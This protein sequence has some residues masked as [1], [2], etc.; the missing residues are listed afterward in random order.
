M[1]IE[2][3]VNRFWVLYQMHYYSQGF[4]SFAQRSSAKKIL[5]HPP[6]SFHDWKPKFFFIK[7]GVIPMKMTFR[8]KEDVVTETIQTPHSET[9]YQDLKDVSSIEL[10]E[11]ALVAAGMSLYWKMDCEDRQVYME[12]DKIVSLNVVAYQRENGRLATIPKRVDEELWYLQIIKNFALPRDEDL[13]AQPST[14]AGELTNLGI[15]S[16]KKKQHIPAA[17]IAPKKTNAPR[18]QSLKTKN[19]KGEKKGMHHSPDSWCD[20]VMVSNTLEGLAP[21]VAKKPKAEPRDPFDIPAS[22]PEDPIDFKSSPKPLLKTKAVKREHVEVEA[23]AQP[24]K[25]MPKRKIGKRGNLDAF[26]AKPPPEKP[27]PSVCEEPEAALNDD[28]PPSPSR[29]STVEQPEGT[30]AVE[31]EAEQVTHEENSEVEKPVEVETENVVDPETTGVDVALP[32]S[33]EVVARDPE[34]AKSVP[35]DSV[36]TIPTSTTTSVPTNVVRSPYGDHGFFAHNEEDSPIHLEETPGDYYYRSYSEKK[37][38]EIHM[39]VWKLKK[40][41]TFS[42]WQVCHD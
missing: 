9:W 38:S 25:K 5:L 35:E 6:K 23:E 3:T 15:G 27:D 33:L 29:A 39:P 4:Y 34:K 31:T 1:Y 10:S 41:D 40:G 18:T 37:A 22:N 21:V 24:T 42:D 8:G 2:P 17:V 12:G 11:R 26:I 14:G 30:K 28:L 19:V 20:Y 36:I 13:A 7:V 16:E 32:K